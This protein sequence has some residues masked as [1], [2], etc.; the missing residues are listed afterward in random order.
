MGRSESQMDITDISTPRPKKQR[1]TSLEISLSVLVLLLTII[2]V[3]MIALY[4]TYDDG[5]CK[6][7][8]C[9]KSG[10]KMVFKFNSFT[11]NV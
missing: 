9:I 10:K 5:I 3:T 2:A 6:S 11:S 1:W 4:A 7:S 8:D